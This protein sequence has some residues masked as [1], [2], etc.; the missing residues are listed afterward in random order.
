M[1]PNESLVI[2]AARPDEADDILRLMCE[3]FQM[4]FELAAPIYY[5]DPYLQIE[6]KMVALLDGRIVSCLSIVD[7]VCWIG[8]A[9]VKLGGIAGVATEK[10]HRQQ[11]IAGRLLRATA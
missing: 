6:N 2:R 7:R 1:S 4:D 9:L 11:G 10:T 3:A 8:A 5:S